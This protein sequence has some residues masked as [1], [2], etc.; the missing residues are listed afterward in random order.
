MQTY[1][2]RTVVNK[3]SKNFDGR[4]EIEKIQIKPFSTALIKNIAVIDNN[5]PYDIDTLFKARYIIAN[6]SYYSLFK[7]E[8]IGIDKASIKEAKMHLVIEDNSEGANINRIFNLGKNDQELDSIGKDIF[9]INKIKIENL[10][11]KMSNF[12]NSTDVKSGDG[13]YIDWNAMDVRDINLKAKDLRYSDY[14][15]YGEL[16]SMSLREKSGYRIHNLSGKA[17]AGRGMTII[18]DAKLRDP[19]SEINIDRYV[20]KFDSMDDFRDY[21][22]KVKMEAKLAP[23][24]ISFRSISYFGGGFYSTMEMELNGDAYGTVSDMT[25][26]HMYFKSAKDGLEGIFN[27]RIY[28]LPEVEDM[29]IDVDITDLKITTAGAEAIAK[30]WSYLPE[31]DIKTYAARTEFNLNG[32]LTGLLNNMNLKS[33]ITSSIGSLKTD[34]SLKNVLY[35]EKLSIGGKLSTSNLRV[36]QILNLDIVKE[37]SLETDMEALLGADQMSLDMKQLSVSRL[38]LN[39]Y[40]YTNIAATGQLTAEQFNGKIICNDPNLN[41]LFSGLFTLSSRTNNAIYKFYT[42]IGYAD[43]YAM[44]IDKRNGSK[45]SLE[46]NANF[47]NTNSGDLLGDIEIR[48]LNLESIKGKEDIG[49]LKISSHSNDNI[50]RINLASEFARGTYVGTSSINNF[51]KDI[52]AINIGREIPALMKGKKHEW[53]SD[54]YDFNLELFD[55]NNILNFLSPGVYIAKNSSISAKIDSTGLMNMKLSSQRLAYNENYLKEVDLSLNNGNNQLNGQI[56]ASEIK[57]GGLLMKHNNIDLDAK[58]NIVELMYKFDNEEELRNS[59]NLSLKTIFSRDKKDNNIYDII[60]HPSEIYLDSKRWIIRESGCQ[61]NNNGLVFDNLSLESNEQEITLDGNYSKTSLDTLNL[62]LKEFDIDILN[63]IISEDYQFAGK[64]SGEANLTSSKDARGLLIDISCDS[65]GF[66][67]AEIGTMD[68]SSN[69][70]NEFKRFDINLDNYYKEKKNI[71]ID[72]NYSPTL[73]RLETKV[74][75][76]SMNIAF[77]KVFL[78]GIFDKITGSVSGEFTAQGPLNA[79]D[80]KSSGA[81]INDGW[82]NVEY[83]KVPYNVRGDFSMDEYGVYFDDIQLFDRFKK[84]GRVSGSM[85]YDNFYDLNFTTLIDF[86]NLECMNIDMVG[87]DGFYGNVFGSGRLGVVGDLSNILLDITAT[88]NS[89]QLHIPITSSSTASTT[90]LLK[91]KV[92]YIK[93]IVDPYDELIKKNKK[94]NTS[95]NLSLKLRVN[96]TPNVQALIEIDKENGNVLSGYGAGIIDL[97]MDMAEDI[98]DIKGDYTLSSGN[99]RFVALGLATRDF[100]INSGSSVKFSGD[101]FDTELNIDAIYSTKASLATLIADTTS[102]GSRRE[103]NCGIKLTDKLLNPSLGFS[104]DIPNI[105][106]MI[107]SKVESALSTQ[108]KIQK[109]FLSLLISNSFLPDEQSGVV[110]NSSV[111]YSNVSEIMAN[112]LNNIFQKLDIPLDLGLNYQP[113]DKGTDI[114]DVAISTQLFNN[115][116]LVNGNI[117]NRENSSNTND[118][119]G[120][121]DIDIKLD[122][123]GTLRLNLF[124]HSADQY[125]NYLDNSQRSGIGLTYQQEYNNFIR[126][127]KRLFSSKKARERLKLQEERER[128]NEIKKVLQIKSEDYK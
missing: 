65:T 110:N 26:P 4:I 66:G 29:N 61:F 76:D 77:A 94:D 116:V 99:Y 105:D 37:C 28:G 5:S 100:S 117:G 36:D 83:T 127:I 82:V 120:D 80:I 20:M 73:N 38:N 46:T 107:K 128:Q 24:F 84:N 16:E 124:S 2:A 35:N 97:N 3:I 52:L 70:N 13:P 41:F 18:E 43:L 44:N 101:I 109:Q 81:R 119:V 114:F 21:I 72:A 23:S 112:Q 106:P 53:K 111:L 7:Q 59:A 108:D 123:A 49:N 69:W 17:R 22:N 121:I 113:N 57:A 32:R 118:V 104:I 62:N 40:N 64:L 14:I 86:E 8:G 58:N 103:V 12:S 90:N 34:L 1:I 50:F 102:V 42:N 30:D 19:W 31:L 96:A 87:N 67:G 92:P 55:I 75:L 10:D 74:L 6:F 63:D 25:F 122:R 15:M 27:G 54:E 95:S 79:L 48:N 45:I 89:G 78:E 11:F 60:V 85:N 88:T 47:I 93:Q 126:F 56:V 33:D 9:N 68:I 91:F 125:T 51:F 39:N 71:D 115:R 98:F